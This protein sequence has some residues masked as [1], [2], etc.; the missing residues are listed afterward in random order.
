MEGKRSGENEPTLVQIY[1]DGHAWS[2]AKMEGSWMAFSGNS[3]A[4]AYAWALANIEYIVEAD[5]MGDV[6]RILDRI[7]AGTSTEAAVREVLHS[8]YGDLSQSTAEYLRKNYVR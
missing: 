1:G 7:G 6:E 4:Y 5:G 3:A 8:D 2:L